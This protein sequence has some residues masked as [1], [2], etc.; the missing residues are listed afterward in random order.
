LTGNDKNAYN[1]PM[2]A[3]RFK[4]WAFNVYFEHIVNAENDEDAQ[5]LMAE[6]LD[7]KRVKLSIGGDFRDPKK[8]FTTFEEIKNESTTNDTKKVGTG[9]QMGS[10]GND[11]K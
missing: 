9:A 4:C 6:E 7:K 2:K 1:P 3:Y 5:R 8:S 10:A 11:T